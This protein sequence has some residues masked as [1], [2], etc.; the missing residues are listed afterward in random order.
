MELTRLN[1]LSHCHKI[2]YLLFSFRMKENRDPTRLMLDPSSLFERRKDLMGL[3]L[4]AETMPEVPLAVVDL[5]D[6]LNCLGTCGSS[7]T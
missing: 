7:A 1:L 4:Y 6:L 3:K 5:E 2:L